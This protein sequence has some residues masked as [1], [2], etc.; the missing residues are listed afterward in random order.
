[1]EKTLNEETNVPN[2]N[3]AF[4]EAI[5]M[6]NIPGKDLPQPANEYLNYLSGKLGYCAEVCITAYAHYNQAVLSM[7]CNDPIYL[8]DENGKQWFVDY[9]NS[10]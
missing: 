2:N 10:N 1:M 6:M 7:P 3:S 5:K 9:K 4:D 8:I